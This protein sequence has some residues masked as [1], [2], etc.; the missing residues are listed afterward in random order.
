MSGFIT[1]SVEPEDHSVPPEPGAQ[2]RLLF[3]VIDSGC[4]FNGMNPQRLLR[5]FYM[6]DDSD[7]SSAGSY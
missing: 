4:G 7:G 2:C 5:Q 1:M 6:D 3:K